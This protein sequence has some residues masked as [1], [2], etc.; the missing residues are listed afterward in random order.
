MNIWH[1]LF[2]IP[3]LSI[4]I[5]SQVGEGGVLYLFIAS[6]PVEPTI[7]DTVTVRKVCRISLYV[8]DDANAK[9]YMRRKV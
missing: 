2:H 1:N 4:N 9:L 8:T 3:Q 7:K 5:C 6:F